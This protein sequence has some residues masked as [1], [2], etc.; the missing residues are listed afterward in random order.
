[1]ERVLDIAGVTKRFGEVV[2]NDQLDL[3]V[4]PGEVVGL[5]GH[6]GAGKTTLVHQVVGLLRPDAG[7]IRVAGVDAVHE[8]AAARRRVAVQAQTHAPVDGLTPRTAIGLAGRLRGLAPDAAADAAERIAATLAIEPW[9]DQRAGPEGAGLSGGVRRLTALAMTLVAPVPLVVL[10]EPTNDV[11][12]PRRRRLWRALRGVAHRGA[13]VLLVTH[14]VTEAEHAVDR[15]VILDR[16]RLVATG[17]PGQLRGADRDQLRLELV[18]HTGPPP[19][20]DRVPFTVVQEVCVGRRRLVTLP[21]ADAGQAL[22]WAMGQR[23][24]EVLESFAITPPSLEEAYLAVTQP[25]G[26]AAE[27]NAHG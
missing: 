3:Q 17:T 23:A 25:E 4:A 11:D 27:P 13:G 24:R 21:A 6:N 20:L 14:N 8:P 16:G 9:L 7:R 22:D 2:A 12:P 1:M 19:E 10:D 26:A 18:A 5:L 15:L